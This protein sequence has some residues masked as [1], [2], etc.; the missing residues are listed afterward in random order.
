MRHVSVSIEGGVAVVVLCRGKVNAID[1]PTIDELKDC[2]RELGADEGARA[3]VFSG[4]GKFFSFGFD[5]PGFL[6]H[7][8]PEFSRFLTK[9]TDLYT[10]LF[11]YPKPVVAALNGHTVAGGLM[12]ALACDRR[13]MT[14]GKGKVALN[15]LAFGSSVFAGSV[16]ML[17]F[18]VGN[19]NAE[20][21][22]YTGAMYFPEEALR[23]G[24][25]DEVCPGEEL[26]GKAMAAARDLGGKS[27][28]AFQSIK[29][30][31]RDPVAE[32]MRFRESAS[33]EEFVDIWYS[34]ATWRNLQE[35]RIR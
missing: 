25:V 21:V 19:R 1:E 13:F 32:R 30:L 5:I 16:E 14:A 29:R 34:E 15:E 10:Y 22:L 28:P 20:E 17:R 27:Q 9:F 7:S 23:L 6:G 33:I 3:V 2:F 12:L 4:E 31:M 35:I 18:A 8:K 11:T 24:L 26:L